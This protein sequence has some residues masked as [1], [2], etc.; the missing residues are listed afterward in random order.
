MDADVWA[1]P[2]MYR[3]RSSIWEWYFK[4]DKVD[5][6]KSFRDPVLLLITFKETVMVPGSVLPVTVI[7]IK[8]I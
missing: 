3:N 7:M 6:A 4:T 2:R 5:T 8:F 1:A